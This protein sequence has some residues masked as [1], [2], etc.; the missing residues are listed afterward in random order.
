M[1]HKKKIPH[2]NYETIYLL[3]ICNKKKHIN[4]PSLAE[5]HLTHFSGI[6]VCFPESS[7]FFGRV[8]EIIYYLIS[9]FSMSSQYLFRAY[10]S[11]IYY[12]ILI[13]VLFIIIILMSFYYIYSHRFASI[14]IYCCYC[15]SCY[16]YRRCRS[17]SC[18]FHSHCSCR[19]RRCGVA[20]IP[21]CVQLLLLWWQLFLLLL[22][23]LLFLFLLLLLR[24]LL[25]LLLLSL[26]YLMRMFS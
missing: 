13:L 21:V 25:R 17:G 20:V 16:G 24:L 11:L 12:Y 15:S 14:I 3:T 4:S 7:F 2:T 22:L 8:G 18:I 23:F 1:I 6:L 19:C 26:P 5:Q 10:L 9:Y